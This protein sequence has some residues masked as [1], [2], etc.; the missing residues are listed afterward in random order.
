[1]RPF[2]IRRSA[3]SI[4]ATSA[5]TLLAGTRGGGDRIGDL[6]DRGRI[7]VGDVEGAA[8]V[9][10]A[11]ADD[12]VDEIVDVDPADVR[13]AV[14]DD[15]IGA[16]ADALDEAAARAVDTGHTKHRDAAGQPR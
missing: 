16:G 10:R 3:V 2:A 9:T 4:P 6:A 13:G 11:G 12:R 15:P 7:V 8:G 14:A 1:M 5:A